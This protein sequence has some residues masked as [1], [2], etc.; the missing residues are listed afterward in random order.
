[1]EYYYRIPL[2]ILFGVLPSLIWLFYYLRKDLHP[3]PK[4]RIIEVFIYGILVTVPVFLLQTQLAAL[5]EQLGWLGWF[6]R[7]LVLADVLK[8]FVVIAFTEELLKYLAVKLTILNSSAVDEPLDVML[9]MVVVAL[10]FAALENIFYLFSPIDNLSLDVIVKTTVSISFIRFVGA[11]FL[12][13]L[14]SGILGYCIALSYCQPSKKFLFTFWG[15]LL[16]T[17]LH[18]LYDFSIITLQAPL[19]YLIP[20]GIILGLAVAVMAAFDQLKKIKGVCVVKPQINIQYAT[21][22]AR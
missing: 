1:M 10:G 21:K 22:K 5:L 17:L 4:R 14:C 9:Y 19:N 2:Y 15:I 7:Y 8:W 16:A 13:T 11:T 12:H 18:G 6:D 3:E 20:L